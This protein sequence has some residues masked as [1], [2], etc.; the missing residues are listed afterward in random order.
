MSFLTSH[1]FTQLSNNCIDFD[2][3]DDYVG[4]G[5]VNNL[6]N[7]NFTLEA[8][9]FV[10]SNPWMSS[11]TSGNT[12]IKKGLTSVGTPSNAGY[13]LRTNKTGPNEIEF[14]IGHS[15]SSTKRLIHQGLILN[16]WIH[17]AG[18][19]QGKKMFLYVNGI[20]VAQ[21]STTTIYNV[22]TNIGLSVGAHDK[23]GLSIVNEFMHGSIDEVR[24]WSYARTQLQISSNMNCAIT[25]P[26]LGLLACYN[27]NNSSLTVVSDSSINGNNGIMYGGPSRLVSSVAPY[28]FASLE[29]TKKEDFKLYP[30]PFDDIIFFEKDIVSNYKIIDLKGKVVMEGTIESKSLNLASLTKGVY[31]IQFVTKKNKLIRKR[32]IK[33]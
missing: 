27:H 13:G 22:N 31:I 11:A 3:V 16:K 28:C 25:S 10:K 29:E 12:I 17:V 24:I 8:W 18:V 4:F 2:G 9:I 30:N 32:I 7:A 1:F 33:A 23:S 5:D 15:N 26:Q 14:H 21:D 6:G 19:R 20:L